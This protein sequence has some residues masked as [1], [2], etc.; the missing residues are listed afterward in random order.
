MAAQPENHHRSELVNVTLTLTG[1]DGTTQTE[2]KKIEEGPTKVTTLKQELGIAEA[3]ALWVVN[4]HGK[5]KPLG[6]HETHDV[7]EG[8]RY[9]ALVRGGVS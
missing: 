1:Q 4:R 7:E 9:E 2:E 5:K 8:D 6:D 3:D